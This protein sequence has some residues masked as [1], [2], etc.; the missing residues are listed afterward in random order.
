MVVTLLAFLSPGAHGQD[1]RARPTPRPPMPSPA[2]ANLPT[3]FLIGDSTVR[4]GRGD[5]ANGQWGWG[6]PLADFFDSAKIDLVNCALGGRSSRTYLTG[7]QWDSVKARLKPGEAARGRPHV[8]LVLAAVHHRRQG[9]GC[10]AHRP[11]PGS[12]EDLE[13]RPDRSLGGLRPVGGGSGPSR[14]CP[15]R[16]P[17]RDRRARLRRPWPRED[18]AAVRGRAHAHDAAGRRARSPLCG[19]GAQG[20]RRQPADVLLLRGGP[21]R[22]A[23]AARRRR[24]HWRRPRGRSAALMPAMRSSAMVAQSASGCT[25]SPIW[26]GCARCGRAQRAG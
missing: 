10:H 11:F 14:A 19:G 9:R 23:G 6:E 7:G 2:A 25:R 15:V 3:L 8:R 20:T 24:S 22:T 21:G 4:N 17:Q 12:Q 13:G 18:R 5:G 1:T 16:R 26:R